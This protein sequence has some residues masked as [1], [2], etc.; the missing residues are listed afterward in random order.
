MIQLRLLVSVED[1]LPDEPGSLDD[2]SDGIVAALE[3]ET[4]ARRAAR[5]AV[6]D[7]VQVLDRWRA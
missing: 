1:D 5:S 3:G 6:V 2:V 7:E 4:V